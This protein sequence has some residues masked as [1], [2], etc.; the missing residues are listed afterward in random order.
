MGETSSF[1]RPPVSWL[2]PTLHFHGRPVG[3][4]P[5]SHHSEPPPAALCH[6]EWSWQLLWVP[7]V[8][9]NNFPSF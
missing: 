1:Q 8:I 3:Q 6:P 2:G 9:Q 7:W 4:A 5:C